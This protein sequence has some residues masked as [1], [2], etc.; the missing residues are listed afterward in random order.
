VRFRSYGL[1]L[2]GLSVCA[3]LISFIVAA[4]IASVVQR[5]R[6]G[7][8]SSGQ[9]DSGE[10][11]V[12]SWATVLRSRY[13]LLAFPLGFAL[14]LYLMLDLAVTV[15]VY[16]CFT[17]IY[18]AFWILVL[19]MLLKGSPTR[20]RPVILALLVL[21]LFSFRFIDWNSRKPF[22]R[23]LYSIQK[24]MT[25]AQVEQ[26]MGSYMRGG[27]VPLGSPSTTRNEEGELVTGTISYRHT[28]EGW[29]NSDWG[30]VTFGNGRV[31]EVRFSPD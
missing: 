1:T 28:D 26:I 21:V 5:L 10:R 8:P 16:P 18:A 9:P 22:L 7:A 11:E 30:L 24:G 3:G 27:E 17:T 15:S 13:V 14:G 2:I 12:R 6:Q 20:H 25:P 19:L 23:D 31:V 29:G 4:L